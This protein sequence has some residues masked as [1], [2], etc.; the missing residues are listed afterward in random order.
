MSKHQLCT[1]VL[2]N[3][4]HSLMGSDPVI[5]IPGKPTLRY[6][7]LVVLMHV[8]LVRSKEP[9]S[10]LTQIQ[11]HHRQARGVAR[12]MSEVDARRKLQEIAMEGLPVQIHMKVLRNIHACEMDQL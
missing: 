8:I 10:A 1:C 6:V 5:M 3:A 2:H 12:S 11:L 4:F 9:W 7:V